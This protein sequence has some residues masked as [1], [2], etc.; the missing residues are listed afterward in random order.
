VPDLKSGTVDDFVKYRVTKQTELQL[1][2]SEIPVIEA[3]LIKTFHELSVVMSE[4]QD[5][6]QGKLNE[7]RGQFSG[8]YMT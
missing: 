7:I 2:Y 3:K 1:H 6:I 4:Q 5:F 8:H